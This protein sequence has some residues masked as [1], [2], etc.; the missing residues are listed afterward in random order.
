MY[1]TYDTCYTLSDINL[2][3]FH[4]VFQKSCNLFYSILQENT[5]NFLFFKAWHKQLINCSTEIKTQRQNSRK[6]REQEALRR[7]VS[8]LTRKRGRDGGWKGREGEGM[9]VLGVFSGHI[10]VKYP[11]ASR[12]IHFCPPTGCSPIALGSRPHKFWPRSIWK[13]NLAA[14]VHPQ[15]FCRDVWSAEGTRLKKRG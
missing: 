13:K 11:G 10:F 12:S 1:N 5:K 8:N 15:G 14:R 3:S 6:R 7:L 2:Q 4:I 9:H